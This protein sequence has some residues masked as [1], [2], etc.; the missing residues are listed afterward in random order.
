MSISPLAKKLGIKPQMR[1]RILAAPDLYHELLE[2]LPDGVGIASAN[3][4]PFTFVQL[5]ATSAADLSLYAPN[6]LKAADEKTLVWIAYPK[7]GS[8]LEGELSR[9]KIRAILRDLGWRAV[10]IIAI[11]EVWSALRFRP[12]A[13]S[14]KSSGGMQ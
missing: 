6:L 4:E 12:I 11:D 1:M 2:P 3:D 5:F 8:R 14:R 13:K 9:D 10:A 7:I